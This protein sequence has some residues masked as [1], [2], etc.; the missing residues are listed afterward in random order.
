MRL[1]TTK[2]GVALL[3]PTAADG[4]FPIGSLVGEEQ[5]T[6]DESCPAQLKASLEAKKGTDEVIQLLMRSRVADTPMFL[7]AMQLIMN[8]VNYLWFLSWYSVF[9]HYQVGEKNY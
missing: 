6:E 9:Q 1:S 3:T 4:G 7:R 8:T 5:T 2:R